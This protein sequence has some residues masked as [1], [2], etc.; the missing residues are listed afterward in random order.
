MPLAWPATMAL[1]Y[2][3]VASS[4]FAESGGASLLAAGQLFA[5]PHPEPSGPSERQRRVTA[6]EAAAGLLEEDLGLRFQLERHHQAADGGDVRLAREAAAERRQPAGMGLHIVVGEGDD[7][8]GRDRH[9][10]VPGGRDAGPG[11][12]DHAHTLEFR[13]RRV[14]GPVIDHDHLVVGVIELGQRLETA[15]QLG[16]AGEVGGDDHARPR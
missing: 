9:P 16:R 8:A 4:G 15:A 2:A 10:A 12:P 11:F 6:I 14:V 1:A 7:L 13:Q 5:T 3:H